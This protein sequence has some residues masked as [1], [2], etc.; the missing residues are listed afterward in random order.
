MRVVLEIG[1][2]G[3]KVAAVAP[4]W[5]GLSRGAKSGD[6]ALERLL[7]YLPRYAPV[8]NLAGWATSLR[9]SPPT[10]SRSPGTAQLTSGA[11]FAFSS[12]DRQVM[13][14]DALE[15]ELALM[16]ACWAFFDGVRGRVSAE[17]QKGPVAEV[18]IATGLSSIRLAWSRTGR[19]GSGS[20]PRKTRRSPSG[21]ECGIATPT[22]KPSGPRGPRANRA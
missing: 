17:L 16:Q 6:A 14:R 3:K 8:A 10:W 9:A 7:A 11:L 12:N 2:K 22:A 18:V 13:S 21:A 5:P 20:T 15:R 19:R 1:P 4:D